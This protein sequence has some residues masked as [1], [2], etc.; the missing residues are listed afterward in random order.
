MAKILKDQNFPGANPAIV[1]SNASTA[2]NC[3][4]TSSLVGLENKKKF[5]FVKTL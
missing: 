3:N 5:F 4:A 1:S 2:E